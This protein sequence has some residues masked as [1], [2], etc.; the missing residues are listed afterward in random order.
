MLF[1]S[2]DEPDEASERNPMTEFF[3]EQR[4]DRAAFEAEI[5]GRLQ[6][7]NQHNRAMWLYGAVGWIAAA[8]LAVILAEVIR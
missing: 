3:A 5:R 2:P 1:R 4:A 6:A 7:L 8:I